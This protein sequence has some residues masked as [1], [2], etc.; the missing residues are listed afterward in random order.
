VKEH[1]LKCWPSAF[2]AVQS[3]AKR[4]EWRR[5]DRGYAVG[6]ILILKL[7]DPHL[8]GFNDAAWNDSHAH[9]GYVAG[10]DGAVI[11]QRARVTYVLRG[12]FGLPPEFCVM[13]IEPESAPP[14]DKRDGRIE[15]LRA[16][17]SDIET[18]NAPEGVAFAPGLQKLARQALAADD[19]EAPPAPSPAPTSDPFDFDLRTWDPGN[20]GTP[21]GV[22]T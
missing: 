17:L 11:Q 20:H 9:G 16:A 10:S 7:W 19:A 13:G 15:R 3:G 4:F 21:G 8:H 12:A 6:D 2:D 18:G 5:D 14:S 1:E 22:G